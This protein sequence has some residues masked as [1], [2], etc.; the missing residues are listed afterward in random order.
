MRASSWASWFL[1]AYA[2]ATKAATSGSSGVVRVDLAF[3]RNETYATSQFLPI[4][5]AVKNAE[6]APYIKPQISFQ[7]WE[8]DNFT[9]SE[10]L[11]TYDLAQ[12]NFSSSEP[13]FEYSRRFKFDKEAVWEMTWSVSWYSCRDRAPDEESVHE[14][15]I[16]YNSTDHFV[17]FTTKKFPSGHDLDLVAATNNTDCSGNLEDTSTYINITDMMKVSNTVDW[18]RYTRWDQDTVDVDIDNKLCAVVPSIAP[19]RTGACSI[20]IG[21]SAATRISEFMASLD[22]RATSSVMGA[23]ELGDNK[24]SIAQRLAVGAVEFLGAA[25]G[26]VVLLLS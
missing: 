19:S 4:V 21:A 17:M 14:Q 5:F 15:R 18:E 7:I 24:E 12:A 25:F 11:D 1:V 13:Y 8:W 23:C 2:E 9:R 3:P 20:A 26:A 16:L 6:L 10:V 22:C